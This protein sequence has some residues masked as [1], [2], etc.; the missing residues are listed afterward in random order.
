MNNIFD[1]SRLSKFIQRQAVLNAPPMLIAAGAIFGMLLVVSILTGYYGP[2]NME[3]LKA[4]FLVVFFFGGFILTSSIFSE[5]H[6]PHKSYFYLTL[7][8]STLE[9]VVGSWILTSRCM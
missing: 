5:L 9:K 3:G 8:V 6:T 4:F 1:I 7:P 2:E